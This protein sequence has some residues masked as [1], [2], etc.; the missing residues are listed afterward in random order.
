MVPV[1]CLGPWLLTS[2][3]PIF[4][5]GTRTFT[6]MVTPMKACWAALTS[7]A[8]TTVLLGGMPRAEGGFYIIQIIQPKIDC[9]Y[10]VTIM[11]P[12]KYTG[13]AQL[14]S[15][16]QSVV[17]YTWR[18]IFPLE[19]YEV[20][21]HELAPGYAQSGQKPT[22]PLHPGG[23][24]ISVQEQQL[25]D[26]ASLFQNEWNEAPL[27]ITHYD[28]MYALSAWD[29][30]W[31]G[32]DLQLNFDWDS[33]SNSLRTGWRFLPSHE[34]NCRIETF[35]AED[36]LSIPPGP[37]GKEKSIMVIGTSVM[38]GV[39][40]SMADLLLPFEDKLRF[41]PSVIGKCW[42]RA[43]VKKGNLRLMYQD[44]RVGE[45]EKPGVN[46][47]DLVECH[48]EQ[49]AKEGSDFLNNARRVWDELF[50]DANKWP[51]TIFLLSGYGWGYDNFDF[52]SHTLYFA[53]NLPQAWRGTL[54]IADGHFSGAVVL[55]TAD[56]SNVYRSD[57]KNMLATIDDSRVRWIDGVGVSKEMKMH[58]EKGTEYVAGSAHFHQKCPNSLSFRERNPIKVCSNI[59]EIVAQLLLG[60]TLGPKRSFWT[61]VG[62]SKSHGVGKMQMLE[63]CTACQYSKSAM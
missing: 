50:E 43:Q 9:L 25:G 33:G 13:V 45:F 11:S 22:F 28:N 23:I 58:T 3:W 17:V 32:P 49:I 21:V 6:S 42:G 26:R 24:T 61:Q 37:D 14:Q 60:Y 53:H 34:M 41:A 39:F 30:T 2:Y 46:G 54:I 31:V 55:G 51:D 44:F 35:S 1:P 10:S 5:P 40:L 20:I 8:L 62:Q 7:T 52:E 48:N 15:R 36:L 4:N 63:T 18:P 57:I 19:D 29:G 38:R 16:D 56:Q 59:T 12:N 47:A 27:C